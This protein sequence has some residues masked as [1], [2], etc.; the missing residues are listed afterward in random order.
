MLH[1]RGGGACTCGVSFVGMVSCG[2]APQD[3]GRWAAAC[4]PAC[5]PACPL[6]AS[7]LPSAPASHPA[8]HAAVGVGVLINHVEPPAVNVVPSQRL[9]RTGTRVPMRI[10]VVAGLWR[11]RGGGRGGGPGGLQDASTAGRLAC[12]MGSRDGMQLT[13]HRDQHLATRCACK[14]RAAQLTSHSPLSSTSPSPHW[15]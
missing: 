7:T 10:L 6:P 9:V 2:R 3:P 12:A 4:L 5:L 14:W 15:A 11:G 1:A 13:P 8:R